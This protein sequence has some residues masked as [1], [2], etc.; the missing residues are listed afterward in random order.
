MVTIYFMLRMCRVHR[1][2]MY[3]VGGDDVEVVSEKPVDTFEEG[4]DRLWIKP[5]D[6]VSI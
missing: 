6:F 4:T 1:K 2:A 3:R 5:L